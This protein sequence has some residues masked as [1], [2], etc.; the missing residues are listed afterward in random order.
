MAF[1]TET[2][3]QFI[4]PKQLQGNPLVDRNVYNI[5]H[6]FNHFENANEGLKVACK[7]GSIDLA[8]RMIEIGATDWDG[9]L[10]GAC[11]GGHVKSVNLMIKRGASYRNLG[12]KGACEG[13]HVELVNLMIE[14]G[15]DNWD[16]GL[17]GACLGGYMEIAN[18]MIKKGALT[19]GIMGFV[20]PV[21]EVM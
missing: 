4:L 7:I 10:C 20:E 8:K 6:S 9:G 1:L 11:R 17:E 16:W 18:Y 19:L 2:E 21:E 12:L 3:F 13:G 15:A 5:I 14:K